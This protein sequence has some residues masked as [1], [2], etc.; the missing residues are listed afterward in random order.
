MISS[1]VPRRVEHLATVGQ[2]V[3]AFTSVLVMNTADLDVYANGVL[4]TEGIDYNVSL[5]GDVPSDGNV[6]LAL[7]AEAGVKYVIE[8]QIQITQPTEYDIGGRFP[9]KSHEAS[10]DRQSIISA[11]LAQRMLRAPQFA[12]VNTTTSDPNANLAWTYTD[13]PDGVNTKVPIFD[14]ATLTV[15]WGNP[16][17][18]VSPPPSFSELTGTLDVSGDD[19]RVE[20]FTKGYAG[21][22]ARTLR[23]HAQ[24]ILCTSDFGLAGDDTADDTVPFQAALDAASSL[25]QILCVTTPAT[26]YRIGPVFVKD[27][28]TLVFDPGVVIHA[29]ATLGVNDRLINIADANQVTI[30]GN[31]ALIDM[32]SQYTSGDQRHGID[33]VG[34][35]L[36]HVE[37][38]R[39]NNCAG[40][41]IHI[42]GS[43]TGATNSCSNVTIRGCIVDSNRRDGMSVVSAIGC[44]VDGGLALN[45][46]QGGAGGSAPQGGISVQPG[47]SNH[48][49]RNVV[50]RNVG[51][52]NNA[53]GP[54]VAV[55][56][57]AFNNTGNPF[58]VL[59]EG[60]HSQEDLTGFQVHSF[61][62]SVTASP[63]WIRYRNGSLVESGIAAIAVRNYGETCPHIEI[64]SPYIVDPN[65]SANVSTKFGAG[66]LVHREVADG[67]E[68]NIGN[69]TIKDA[70]IID[71]RA[72]D[73]MRTGIYV[74][75]EDTD[76]MVNVNILDP[77]RIDW[78]A[79]VAN[80]SKIRFQGAGLIREGEADLSFATGT[81]TIGEG[82]WNRQTNE[83]AVG[84]VTL[85][86]A[87]APRVGYPDLEFEVV[88]DEALV[89]AVDPSDVLLPGGGTAGSISS[90]VV[91]STLRVRRIGANT[92]AVVA[93]SG[94][95]NYSPSGQDVG[96]HA[97]TGNTLDT[98]LVT[99]ALKANQFTSVGD[100]I[101]L[102]YMGASTGTGSKIITSRLGATTI[103]QFTIV[104]DA[105]DWVL[106]VEILIQ[107][108]SAQ[109]TYWHYTGASAGADKLV[110]T[111]TSAVALGSATDLVLSVQLGTSG[112]S[113]TVLSAS[114]DIIKRT[115]I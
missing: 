41:G 13:L 80:T 14:P 40:D 20:T 26:G 114:M 97:H 79:T 67:G 3:F 6:V 102:R 108:A 33:I 15:S 48:S 110:S 69:V 60:H 112:D 4:L 77:V 53:A 76:A 99:F 59:V 87:D 65:T 46:G 27:G 86:L 38:L 37:G 103:G 107:G 8:S 91:G 90:R 12:P 105:I 62:N 100:A 85:T 98:S 31:G 42:S 75:D 96:G 18:P 19:A 34:S 70:I 10:L 89:I 7:G 11:D 94:T 17:D 21:S 83:G 35:G 43:R 28:T 82:S 56:A 50:I 24:N 25:G 111:G 78:A 57:G 45:A 115:S 101:K 52:R 32:E 66:I 39:V 106:D 55:G 61:I 30:Y 16:A 47:A 22:I 73:L 36:V 104:E 95:W 23:E 92:W 58:E 109:R 44:L 72:T 54:G 1:E 29:I 2:T 63:G 68:T 81:G 71:T 5:A 84:T 9:A 74:D 51:T 49:I 88:T 113:F 64:D 93:Q